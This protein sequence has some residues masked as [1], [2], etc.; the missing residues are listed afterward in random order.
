MDSPELSLDNSWKQ[1]ALASDE[2]RRAI[3]RFSIRSLVTLSA[4]LS[5]F[6]FFGKYSPVMC[7]ARLGALGIS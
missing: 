6:F 5:R 3:S 7:L 4:E 1:K 2:N